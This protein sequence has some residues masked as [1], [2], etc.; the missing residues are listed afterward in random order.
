MDHHCPWIGNCVGYHNFKV[1]FL[2][3]WYQASTGVVYATYMIKFVF[4]SPDET[5]ELSIEGKI[6]YYATNIFGMTISLALIPLTIQIFIQ[7][8]NNIT[9]IEQ[10]AM[11]KTK[12][13]LIGTPKS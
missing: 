5:P 6:C 10:M 9:S 2:F 7:I 13:P 3:C 12:Y 1:F 4:F 11:K 8:Y